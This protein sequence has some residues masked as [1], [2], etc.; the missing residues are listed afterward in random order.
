[1]HRRIDVAEVPLVGGNLPA[2]VEIE[3]AQHQQQLLL[4]E[5]EIHQRQGN[6]VEGQI[7]GRIPRILPL[8]RHG[9]HVGVEHVEPFRVAHVVAGGFEQRMTLVLAQPL[10]QVEVVVLLAPQHSRQRL[11]VHPALIFVQRLRR[12][13]LVEFVGVGDPAFEYPLETA[14]GIF[15][16][17]G[18]QPQPDRLAARRRALRAT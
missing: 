3:A 17:G 1:M 4:G 6:R 9:D 15:R 14:E 7:P 11:A 5:I 12:N 16:R 2:R 10:L 18:R 13:P 8:V